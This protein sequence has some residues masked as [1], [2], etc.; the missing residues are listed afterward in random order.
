MHFFS[1]GKTDEQADKQPDNHGGDPMGAYAFGR[2]RQAEIMRK[3][4][5]DNHPHDK[6]RGIPIPFAGQE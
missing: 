4:G 6:D 5:P 2:A 3:S 1:H